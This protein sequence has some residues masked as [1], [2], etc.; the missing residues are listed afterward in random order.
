MNPDHHMTELHLPPDSAV[1]KALAVLRDQRNNER[2][3]NAVLEDALRRIISTTYEA[4]DAGALLARIRDI[5]GSTLLTYR[6]ERRVRRRTWR[7]RVAAWW[8]TRL[9]QWRTDR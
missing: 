5:A 8:T 2:Q 6:A 1:R 7:D 3:A 4:T 9:A